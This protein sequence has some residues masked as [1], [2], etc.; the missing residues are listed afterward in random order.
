MG[1]AMA[2]LIVGIMAV[3]AL[4]LWGVLMLWVLVTYVLSSVSLMKI[5][6]KLGVEKGWLAFIPMANYWLMG[7]LAEEDGKRYHPEKKQK[8]WGKIYLT[9]GIVYLV[10]TL[11]LTVAFIIFT[12]VFTIMGVRNGEMTAASVSFVQN[13]VQIVFNFL[14]Y[15]MMIVVMIFGYIVL[16]KLYHVMAGSSATWMLILSIF[17]PVAQ[18]V[19]M[20]LLAFSSKYPVE[21]PYDESGAF[22][23]GQTEEYAVQ[24]EE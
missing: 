18:L 19:I 16:Y 12:T 23:E 5:S 9:A 14:V 7:K 24:T 17:V 21:G 6:K 2:A 8:K 1:N 11:L 20:L 22:A 4:A 3:I 13:L 15:A 10:A